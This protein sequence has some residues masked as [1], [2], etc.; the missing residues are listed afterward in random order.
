MFTAIESPD[1]NGLNERLNQTLVNRI[2]CHINKN[3]TK[4]SWST[5]AVAQICVKEYSNTDI[6]VRFQR[7]NL[8]A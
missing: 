6:Y 4:L 3:K 8:H 5:V 1:S 2:R 7:A